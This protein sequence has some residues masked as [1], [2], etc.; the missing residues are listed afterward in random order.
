MKRLIKHDAFD[1]VRIFHILVFAA[2]VIY[3]SLTVKRTRSLFSLVG[4]SVLIILGTLGEREN[5]IV[6]I[7]ILT[8]E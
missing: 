5:I 1:F 7:L 2:I 8:N 3:I 4:I 6:Q